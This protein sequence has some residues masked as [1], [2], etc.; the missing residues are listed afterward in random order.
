[1]ATPAICSGRVYLRTAVQPRGSSTEDARLRREEVIRR[2]GEFNL[3]D[4]VPAG[5]SEFLGALDERSRLPI[6]KLET[7]RHIQ[8]VRRKRICSAR[9][10]STPNAASNA[11]P[12]ITSFVAPV[13]AIWPPLKSTASGKKSSAGRRSCSDAPD[14]PAFAMELGQRRHQFKLMPRCRERRSARRAAGSARPG[15]APGR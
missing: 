13:A 4:F 12:N 15:P 9:S 7:C 2:G 6:G 1:M 8:L 5:N 11:A 14:R 3:R 10:T